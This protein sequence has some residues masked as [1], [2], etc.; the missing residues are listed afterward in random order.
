MSE[1]DRKRDPPR[2]ME[3]ALE[4]SAAADDFTASALRRELDET[5][6]EDHFV[7]SPQQF[8][9]RTRS[10]TV[11]RDTSE[12][13][14]D[15][16][17][18]GDSA[19][20]PAELALAPEETGSR[21]EVTGVVGSGGTSK[22]FALFDRSLSRTVA[23][24]FL[25]KRGARS[26][27]VR[28]RFV[29][30]ARVTAL[31]EH[32]NIMPV[33]DIGVSPEG[34]VY[35]T[36]KRIV[37]CSLGDAIRAAR[38]VEPVPEEFRTIDGRIRIFL[39]VCDALSFAH[40]K[41]YIHQDVKPDNI[42]LGDYGEV[43]LVDWG[44]A[45]SASELSSAAG[46]AMYG[47]PAFMSPEQ[48]RREMVD[49]RSDVYCLGATMFQ[50]LLLRHP[51]WSEDPERF[52]T[53]KREGHI[54]E[55]TDDERVNVP[56]ALLAIV[57]KAMQADRTK[58]Y[59]SVA[60][61]AE[62]LKRYQAGLA[63][64]AHQESV[65]EAFLRWYRKNRR[66]FWIASVSSIL[67]LGTAVMLLR[68]KVKE[69]LTWSLVYSENF[70][71]PTTADLARHWR[72]YQ[73]GNWFDF[74]PEEISDSGS[75][76]VRDGAL[77]ARGRTVNNLS[78]ALPIPG[79]IRVEWD[80][81]T[82]T[83]NEN[84]NCFIAGPVRSGGYM[85]HIGGFNN[86]RN[87]TLSKGR[88]VIVLDRF[89][90]PVGVQRNTWY[91]YRVEK[92]SRGVRLFIDG[93]KLFDYRD[94]DMLSGENHQSFGIETS[95]NRHLVFDNVRV[96]HHA[97]PLKVSPL[98]TPDEFYERGHIGDALALYRSLVTA[99]PGS[100]PAR[101]AA[102]KIGRCLAKL[103]SGRAAHDAFVWFEEQFPRH[104]L[105]PL[106]VYERSR[107]YETW[108]DT[109]GLDSAYGKLAESHR[110]HPVARILLAEMERSGRSRIDEYL[111]FLGSDSAL[112]Q[113]AYAWVERESARMRYWLGRF[114]VAPDS[115]AFMRA[116][117]SFWVQ[118]EVAWPTDS[119][120]RR[121]PDVRFSHAAHL[122]G[123]HEL[124]RVLAEY[125]EYDEAVL[126]A[127]K[128]TGNWNE[129]L[130]RFGEN[131]AACAEALFNLGQ[132]DQL[133]QHYPDLR[134]WCVQV[135]LARREYER[136]L[137][138]YP[139]QRTACAQSLVCLGRGEEAYE[140]YPYEGD[141]AF[142]VA[143][144]TGRV[145]EF[146]DRVSGNP[147]KVYDLLQDQ[148]NHADSAWTIVAARGQSMS[149]RYRYMRNEALHSL[150][151]ADSAATVATR[152]H[153]IS[154]S[155]RELGQPSAVIHRWPRNA[156]ARAQ[157]LVEQG[158]LDSA[159]ALT[160]TARTC[161]VLSLAGR[162]D[163]V[164]RRFPW[165]RSA[166]AEALYNAGECARVVSTYHDQRQW[167]ARALLAL[168]QYDTL[169]RHFREFREVCFQ[170]LLGMGR[171]EDALREFPEFR[172]AF[173]AH[174]CEQGRF[175]DVY[176]EFRD[177]GFAFG[178]ACAELRRI[179][180]IP[181]DKGLFR[182]SLTEECEVRHLLSLRAAMD[183]SWREAR[184][185]ARRAHTHYLGQGHLYTRFAHFL[186]LPVVEAIAGRP[187]VL[188]AACDSLIAHARGVHMQALWYEAAYL[189]N[190]VSDSMFLAQPFRRGA[191]MRLH[192]FRGIRRELAGNREG[193]R[194]DY[195]SFLASVQ[196]IRPS[197]NRDID[198]SYT[199]RRFARWRL[200]AFG[201]PATAVGRA[202]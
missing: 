141:W 111:E 155:L 180:E 154:H 98:A 80:V 72:A 177:D 8:Y 104:E 157:S 183:G 35:F 19:E 84:I 173:A 146:F 78:F 79:D 43:L 112:E 120:L 182:M 82:G 164:L 147:E 64:T 60:E 190:D 20:L 68:E 40:N 192:L 52:W 37:G 88:Q 195:E 198:F 158:L 96:Y 83:A 3:S 123:N 114:G 102:F 110:D 166:A 4:R 136:I 39:K 184:A 63:V 74:Q 7:E 62:D 94:P 144:S 149:T 17:R 131:R 2:S 41:G 140:R 30:E 67:I 91:H 51:T 194:E 175:H 53:R 27:L 66:V 134:V 33:H 142:T 59:G 168:E 26:D 189:A 50:A 49:E 9:N 196:R 71:T 105:V 38:S 100:E 179:E 161:Y 165:H 135:L 156:A 5:S 133:L 87:Y 36:M 25:K 48:A 57:L 137:E 122:A 10:D 138:E 85:F 31:L 130:R 115:N 70:D 46:R 117:A 86:S 73:S 95:G 160:M 23:V 76:V 150:G 101:V 34:D 21:F 116:A 186:L 197:E 108:G 6:A 32:P 124:E 55:P 24:K 162:Y 170:A 127:L 92:D 178:I 69:W 187:A 129:V 103:D 107:L 77:H 145:P 11:N 47:T 58:R 191:A 193:A 56:R 152:T 201:D 143:R 172:A 1:A 148:L 139:D 93:E 199:T 65:L 75:W 185:H 200:Q 167:C 163:E 113:E 89:I 159:L 174:L 202:P 15:L 12:I 61:L 126:T 188:A 171:E 90:H 28:R 106:A 99:Y 125:A 176:R 121:Y 42:M 14:I 118:P 45:L 153:I 22:V 128:N 16:T 181:F 109:A 151:R 81:Y 18:F 54:D 132:F 29:H 169:C 44:S 97:L 13:T 119:M